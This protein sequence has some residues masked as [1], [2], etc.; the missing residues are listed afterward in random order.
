[1]DTKEQPS[2][3]T[4]LKTSLRRRRN[5]APILLLVAGLAV[6]SAALVVY[7]HSGADPLPPKI[8]PK[9]A[10][11]DYEATFPNWP[12]GRKPEFVIVITGQT[13]G[14]LQKC[15]CSDPQKGGLERRFNLIE[16]FKNHG[17]EAIPIDLGDV[18][19]EVSID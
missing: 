11:W 2:L 1:M 8:E 12:K 15:G 9:G 10:L 6:G 5:V 3:P 18:A 19:P 17:I 7:S 4:T 14:Y 13:Y 16:G